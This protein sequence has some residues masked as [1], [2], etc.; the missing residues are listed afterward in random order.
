[1]TTTLFLL[2]AGF[3]GY[4]AIRLHAAKAD[5]SALRTN[6]ASLKRRLKEHA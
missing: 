5:N 4:L 1:M 6:V 3:C 2:L